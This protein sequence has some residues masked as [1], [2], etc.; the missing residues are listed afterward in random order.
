VQPPNERA[1]WVVGGMAIVLRLVWIGGAR[2]RFPG[3][4]HLNA[5]GNGKAMRLW[6]DET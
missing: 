4:P 5:I 1:L 6:V 2:S 3:P